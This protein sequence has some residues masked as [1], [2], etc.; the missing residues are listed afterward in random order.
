MNAESGCAGSA[1]VLLWRPL[2]TRSGRRHV[3]TPV[4]LPSGTCSPRDCPYGLKAALLDR[5]LLL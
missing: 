3:Q 2:S 5:A 1:P 4:H